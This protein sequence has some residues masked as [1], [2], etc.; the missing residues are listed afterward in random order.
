MLPLSAESEDSLKTIVRKHLDW[1]SRNESE[2]E[3]SGKAGDPLLSQ[4]AWRAS[5]EVDNAPFP[6][7]SCVT[8]E[9]TVTLRNGLDSILAQDFSTPQ[10]KAT[11]IAFGFTG[12]ASQWVGMGAALYDTEPVVRNILDQ[13]D[14]W[15]QE[16]QHVGLLDVMFGREGA[17]GNLDDPSWKQPAIYSLEC[18]L[19]ELWKSLGVQ[20]DVVFGHSLGELAA[21]QSAKVFSLQDGLRFAGMR[22]HLTSKLPGNGTMIAVLAPREM[23]T[24]AVEEYNAETTGSGLCIAVD[25][26]RNQVISGPIDDLDAIQARFKSDRIRVAPLGNSPAYHSALVEPA[27]DPLHEALT[28]LDF[29]TPSVDYVSTVTGEKVS[30]GT[31]LDAD[32]WCRQLRQDVKFASCIESVASLGMDTLIEVGPHQVLG[33]LASFV[34]EKT[35]ASPLHTIASLQRPG[36]R[37]KTAEGLRGGFLDAVGQ[38]FELGLEIKFEQLFDGEKQFAPNI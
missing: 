20:P 3:H 30:D 5:V 32:Y 22:G 23:V 38:A 33:P 34:W 13:C 28:N 1:L 6:F 2:L 35:S 14:S 19:T 25:N 15:L 26:G 27:L 31:V 11:K 37:T 16:Y 18:A 7:R 10:P 8:F 24:V 9:D 4:L 29:S 21:A 12:Q 17:R 36:R